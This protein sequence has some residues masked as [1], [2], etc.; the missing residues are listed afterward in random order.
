MPGF[1]SDLSKSKDYYDLPERI[2]EEEL[3]HRVIALRAGDMSQVNPISISLLRLVMSLVQNFA[4]PRR[5]P[6]LIGTALLTLVETVTNAA[7]KLDDNNILPYVAA[8]INMRL[9]DAIGKDHVVC[10]PPRQLRRLRA[11]GIKVT[12]PITADV[13]DVIAKPFRPSLECTEIISKIAQCRHEQILIEL[14]CQQHSLAEIANV[15]GCS[16]GSVYRMKKDLKERFSAL[17]DI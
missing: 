12:V 2:D 17:N 10:V 13:V 16:I 15:I 11:K 9:K 6:D 1:H 5:T 7:T 8:S 3:E 4:H 14:R